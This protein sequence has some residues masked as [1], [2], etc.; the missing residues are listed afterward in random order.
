MKVKGNIFPRQIL[1]SF[2]S[3]SPFLNHLLG[4]GD[5]NPPIKFIKHIYE[6][7]RALIYFFASS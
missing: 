6:L 4:S 7:V 1:I 3:Q 2:L 5:L